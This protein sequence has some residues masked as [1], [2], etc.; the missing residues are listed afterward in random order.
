MH[1]IN[2][3]FDEV[4]YDGLWLDLNEA[5][6][7]CNGECV[8]GTVPSPPLP[9]KQPVRRSLKEK[10]MN[11]ASKFVNEEIL[12]TVTN[13]TWFDSYSDQ[14]VSST[15]NLPFSPGY[16]QMD[17]HSLSLNATHVDG[18]SEFNLH[19]LFGHAQGMKTE[20]IL[21]DI[22]YNQNIPTALKDKRTFILSRSTFAGSG[23][24]VQHWL[25]DN[26]R[27]WES[28]RWSIAGIM[29]FNMFGIP[30]VGAN[31]CG[32]KEDTRLNAT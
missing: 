8:N 9:P 7:F 27:N 31:V 26:D 19:S 24:Y 29:N 11:K 14:T 12:G 22:T 10:I 18:E 2:A 5:T 23:K 30:M 6:G 25:G 17:H 32:A 4:E 21:S 28:M 3:L 1:G 15:Y 13:D 16:Q 20:R